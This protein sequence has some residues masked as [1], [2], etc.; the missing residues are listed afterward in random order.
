MFFKLLMIFLFIIYIFNKDIK[1]TFDNCIENVYNNNLEVFK[2][3]QGK[4]SLGH[5]SN[6]YIYKTLIM[7]SDEPLPVNANFFYNINI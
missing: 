7:S 5:N 6:E 2:K 1:E 3:N 4:M